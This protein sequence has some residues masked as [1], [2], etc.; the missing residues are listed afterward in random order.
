MTRRY[1]AIAAVAAL[2]QIAAVSPVGSGNDA[3]QAGPKG[4][5]VRT[6]VGEPAALGAYAYLV[7]RVREQRCI[8]LDDSANQ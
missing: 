2:S 3:V 4:A 6:N 5:C 8:Y 1:I 7:P